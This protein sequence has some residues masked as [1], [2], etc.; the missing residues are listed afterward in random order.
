MR[1]YRL[2]LERENSWVNRKC[3]VP[4]ECTSRTG[5]GLPCRI[6]IFFEGFTVQFPH[7]WGKRVLFCYGRHNKPFIFVYIIR[8]TVRGDARTCAGLPGPVFERTVAGHGRLGKVKLHRVK[9]FTTNRCSVG[10]FQLTRL[11]WSFRGCTLQVPEQNSCSSCQADF[12]WRIFAFF[13]VPSKRN[14]P[15]T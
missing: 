6:L 11:G 3:W 14:K 5:C 2:R 15:A 1:F 13:L 4:S 9:P 7:I 12:Y 10:P 8:F